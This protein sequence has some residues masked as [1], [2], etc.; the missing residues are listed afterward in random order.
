MEIDEFQVQKNNLSVSRSVHR[1]HDALDDGEVLVEVEQYALTANNITYG[2]V[3]ERI[4]YWQFFPAPDGWGIIPVWG[5]GKVAES[6]NKEVALP[7][8][9]VNSRS[10]RALEGGLSRCE[11]TSRSYR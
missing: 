10:F 6:A 7:D 5:F 4:G 9:F 11:G 2:I 8:S 1:P 3:G